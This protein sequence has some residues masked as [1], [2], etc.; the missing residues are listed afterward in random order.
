LGVSGDHI[1][2]VEADLGEPA[3]CEKTVD[4]IV[5]RYGRID[6]LVNS[7]GANDGIVII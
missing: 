4:A 1:F 3:A 5:R 2:P 6:G 7:S